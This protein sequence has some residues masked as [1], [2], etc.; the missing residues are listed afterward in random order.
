VYLFEGGSFVSP[1]P[2]RVAWASAE[3]TRPAVS[4][5]AT[6]FAVAWEEPHVDGPPTAMCAFLDSAGDP[7]SESYVIATGE[8]PQVGWDGLSNVIAWKDGDRVLAARL[9]DDCTVEPALGVDVSGPGVTDSGGPRIACNPTVGCLIGWVANPAPYVV[10]A[11]AVLLLPDAPVSDGV[12]FQLSDAESAPYELAIAASDVGFLAAWRGITWEDGVDCL[13]GSVVSPD[14]AVGHAG[15]VR[16]ASQ[17][18]S[19]ADHRLGWELAAASDGSA[20]IVGWIETAPIGDG[21]DP[22]E[23]GHCSTTDLVATRI[24]PGGGII[25][26]ADDRIPVERTSSDVASPTVTWTGNS[27]LFGWSSWDLDACTDPSSYDC[28]NPRWNDVR[29]ARVSSG[30]SVVDVPPL[31]ASMFDGDETLPTAVL[32]NNGATLL[33]YQR[34]DGALEFGSNRIRTRLVTGDD[35]EDDWVPPSGGCCRTSRESDGQ[36]AVMVALVVLVSITRRRERLRS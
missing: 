5:A 17:D 2:V 21:C 29:V 31:F 20:Y 3:Q 7:R 23:T 9:G 25:D 24:L 36:S 26:G 22:Q 10:E 6:G 35:T 27:Y 34:F 18:P 13:R 28:G 15:G 12:P 1:S 19:D 14:G 33:A 16:I 4:E 11:S 32:G 8:A 30:G